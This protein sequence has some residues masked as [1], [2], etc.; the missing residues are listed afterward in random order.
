[1]S[2]D[3]RLRV[4]VKV[5]KELG[6]IPRGPFVFIDSSVAVLTRRQCATLLLEAAL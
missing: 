1:M 5:A 4:G 2:D 6:D 3:L